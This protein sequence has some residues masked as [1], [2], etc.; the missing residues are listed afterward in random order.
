MPVMPYHLG[1]II[2]DANYDEIS[3]NNNTAD[4]KRLL[5]LKE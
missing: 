5:A 1:Q 4:L 3:L 2:N